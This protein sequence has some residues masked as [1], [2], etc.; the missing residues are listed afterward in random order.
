MHT[1]KI[2]AVYSLFWCVYGC[3]TTQVTNTPTDKSNCLHLSVSY[4][5]YSYGTYLCD[6]AAKAKT[7][8]FIKQVGQ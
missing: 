5:G 2:L 3:K 6:S 4:E 1:I 7:I 8:E